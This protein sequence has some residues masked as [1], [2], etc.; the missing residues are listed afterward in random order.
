MRVLGLGR[1]SF[2]GL[3]S[4]RLLSHSALP[5]LQY[6]ALD[7]LKSLDLSSTGLVTTLPPEWSGMAALT[8]LDLTNV[9]GISGTLPPECVA[10]LGWGLAFDFFV[11]RH[12]P[13]ELAIH[14]RYGALTTLVS[15]S[16]TNSSLTG[17]SL[18]L[19]VHLIRRRASGL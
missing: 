17:V 16:I 7:A 4:S 14:C 18:A 1:C 11:V 12:W 9:T 8:S 15:L 5:P 2:F 19:R 3:C 6:A 13:T 10:D